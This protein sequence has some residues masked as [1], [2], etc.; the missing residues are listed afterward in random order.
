MIVPSASKI[1]LKWARVTAERTVDYEEGVRH[2]LKDWGDETAN[3]EP[4]YEAGLKAA[5]ARKAFG[6][7]VRKVGTAHQKSKTIIK[8]IP[9]WAEGVRIAEDDMKKGMEPV[10]KALEGITLPERFE[11]GDPRNLKRVE[12]I[13]VALHKLKT[14]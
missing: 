7:G 12:A 2:P 6:K 9:R 11:T 5:M 13:M 14:G 4:R 3:A 10:V 1:A 8:G